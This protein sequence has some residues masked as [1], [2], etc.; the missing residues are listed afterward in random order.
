M[1]LSSTDPLEPLAIVGFSLKFPGTAISPESFWDLILQGRPTAKDVP[2]DRYSVDAW[3]HPDPSHLDTVSQRGGNFLEGDLSQFDAAFFSITASEANAMVPQQRMILE[4]SY[5]ALENAGITM[6]DVSGSKMAVF[7]GVFGTDYQT[8]HSKDPLNLPRFNATG[9]S[10]NMLANR[11]SWFF[12]LDG[13]S[14]NVDTACSSSL[15]AIHLTCQSIWSGESCSGLAIGCNA[16][17]TPDKAIALDNISVLSGD[18]RSYSFDQ[19]ANGYSRGE[20]VG[21]LVIRPLQDAISRGDPIRA[22]IRASALNQ[23]GRTP[24]ITQPSM[25]R[26]AELIRETY[27]RAGLDLSTTRYFETHGTGTSVGDLIESRSIGSVFREYRSAIDP[28]YLG[29]VK[30]NIGHLEGASGVA[31]VIK[32]VLALEKGV[33]PPNSDF[34]TLNPRIDDEFFHLKVPTDA[35]P[36]PSD[37]LRRASISSFG[38]GGSNAHIII[39]DAANTLRNRMKKINSKKI[40][41]TNT[42]LT[43]GS[44]SSMMPNGATKNIDDEAR[45]LVWS[46]ADKDG[47]SRVK[48]AWKTFFASVEVPPGEKCVYLNNLAFTLSIRRSSLPWKSFVVA[49]PDEDWTTMV[50]RLAPASLANSSPNV[51]YIFSGQGAQWHAM[52]RELIHTYPVF[53]HSL[54]EA[55]KYLRGLGCEWDLL[56]TIT[57]LDELCRPEAESNVNRTTYSQTL[58]T[59]L[60]VALVDL[61]NSFGISPK[62]VVGHSSGEIAAAYTA[63]AIS[64]T[65]AWRIAY[66]RGIWGSFLEE[67]SLVRGAMLAVALPVDEISP[68]FDQMEEQHPI[69]RLTVACINSPRS[70]TI[71]GEEEQIDDL[72]DLLDKQ[73]VFNRKLKVKAAY[74]SFQMHEIAKQ[75]RA[76]MG[77]IESGVEQPH[78]NLRPQVVSLLTGTWVE[79]G[80]LQTADYWVENMIS[81]VRF[82]DSLNAIASRVDP[83]TL[84]LDGSHLRS[85]VIHQVIEIGPHSALQGPVK[86]VLNAAASGYVAYASAIVNGVALYPA[87]GML[88]MAIEGAKQLV[89]E[90]REVC[91]FT[92]QDTVF[93]A[94]VQILEQEDIE[95]NFYMH[96]VKNL[97]AKDSDLFEFS[98]YTEALSKVFDPDGQKFVVSK[99]AHTLASTKNTIHPTA[100]DSIL[101][102]GIW[103]SSKGDTKAFPTC[104]PTHLKSIWISAEGLPGSAEVFNVLT[105]VN[106]DSL[107]D[108]S[109]GMSVFDASMNR[110][111]MVI[112]GLEC[113]TVNAPLSEKTN[114]P[115]NGNF[116]T[117]IEFKPDI[118]LLQNDEIDR[119]CRQGV[120]TSPKI[121]DYMTNVHF[122]VLAKV[123]YI[124]RNISQQEFQ[125]K[126]EWYRKYIRWA[127]HQKDLRENGERVFS[128]GPWNARLQDPEFIHQLEDSVSNGGVI[129]KLAVSVSRNLEDMLT[130][131]VDPLEFIF[132]SGLVK[133]YYDARWDYTDISRSFFG[134]AASEFK[135]EG[136]RMD[137]KAL[138]IEQNPEEQG[139]QAGSYDMVLASLVLHATADL[140]QTLKN[141]RRLLKPGGKLVMIEL[142]NPFQSAAT[143]GLLEGWWLSSESYRTL[144]PAV[145]RP[146]WN[147]LLCQSGF[148]GCDL[149]CSDFDEHMLNETAVIVSTAKETSTSPDWNPKIE[150]V[151][152]PADGLQSN[153]ANLLAG[154]CLALR[155]SSH[156]NCVSLG[157]ASSGGDDLFR[158]F[159]LEYGKPALFRMD[160]GLFDGLRSLLTSRATTLWITYSGGT[161]C[162]EPKLHLIDDLFRVLQEE[163]AQ[164]NRFILSLQD[165]KHSQSIMCIIDRIL[166]SPANLDNEYILEHGKLLIPRMVN[167]SR[168]DRVVSLQITESEEALLPFGCGGPLQLDVKASSMLGG[169]KFVQAE[170]PAL[171]DAH[172]V[173]VEV[174]Y[175][176]VNF[177]DVLVALGQ[178]PSDDLGE[179]CMGVVTR[180]G[181]SCKAFQKGDR[182][183]GC[184]TNCYGMRARFHEGGA[185]VRIPP[186]VSSIDAVTI[187]TNFVT[188]YIAIADRAHIQCGESILI[189]S[190]SGGT[191]QA[192]IQIAQHLGA[193][194]FI[195]VG[196]E[197]KTRFMMQ[198]YNIPES[199]IFSSRSMAFAKAI[200]HRTAGRGVDVVLNSLS[201]EG[202]IQSWECIALYGRFVEIGVRDVLANSKLPMGQFL[203]NVTFSALDISAM[204]TER[205]DLCR[206]AL[207]TL[208]T[209]FEEGKL[210]PPEPIQIYGIGQMEKAFRL[211]QSGRNYGKMVIEMR[212]EDPVMTLQKSQP[213]TFL[214][215]GA[216]YVVAGGLGGLGQNLIQWL[217]G[218]GAKHLMILS[219]SGATGQEAKLL[220]GDLR[221]RG[222]T[223]RCPSCD[224]SDKKAVRAVFEEWGPQMPPIKGCIQAAMVLEDT[225]FDNMSYESWNTAVQPKTHGSWNLH[226]VLPEAGNTFQDAL[227]HYRNSIGENAISLDL[228][229]FAFAGR[230]A[231]DPELLARALASNSHE[232]VT[233]S[234]FHA[235]LDCYCN[236]EAWRKMRLPIQPVVGFRTGAGTAASAYWS[237]KPMMRYVTLQGACEGGQDGPGDGLNLADAF[238]S[239]KSAADA[240][241][242]VQTALS[243][244]L[245]G[246]LSLPEADLDVNKPLQ[247]YGVDSLAAV[248]LRGWFCKE[249]Q[250]DIATFDIIGRA[251]IASLAQLATGR[252]KLAKSWSE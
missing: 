199:R 57:L 16:I 40:K 132:S 65:S 130:E 248:E 230:L 117:E 227:A 15:M 93:E 10:M 151:C 42:Q 52:G 98:L 161:A 215:P 138:N 226:Q 162:A 31:G 95:V 14:A 3:H 17:L 141:V 73:S 207:E 203:R 217:L 251:T 2:S 140:L 63:G 66:Y 88:V 6:T 9:T 232:P 76:A 242:S 127:E 156:V 241:T 206:V 86:E 129:G 218:R 108:L 150:I 61:L 169:F 13:P 114:N 168:L 211:M 85:L 58:C 220:V 208:V 158:I 202:L 196:S 1:G 236:P 213:N 209:L 99:V 37:G 154:E 131:V 250:A 11:V 246:T 62:V 26:Q 133:N 200:M 157:D 30:S 12:N 145:D 143:F 71:S 96:P 197:E 231:R 116:S 25:T 177:H 163:D 252:S 244:K 87:A 186:G 64:R 223:I 102:T 106:S 7:S 128:S 47:L 28:L 195:T 137:F 59:A 77:S 159:L 187:P 170:L 153:L 43:N 191:G 50:D 38:F 90:G 216:T 180:V 134:N 247:Q 142:I 84:K 21:V 233:E 5:R 45:L 105:R 78:A 239:A 36:W 198:K 94:T 67:H 122:L 149:F 79:P 112:D 155:P 32:A 51:A 183:A 147:A 107:A 237:E 165:E 100:L 110:P 174:Y 109:Y 39:D 80:A 34:Q 74:H 70:V 184:I 172:K 219:R 18:S 23:D 136:A 89:R 228:G 181:E 182:V 210:H 49:R 54:D 201:G 125:P 97:S 144:G 44:Q 152:D 146:Q 249:V 160:R 192:A 229:T 103:T 139:F 148:S 189:H 225:R 24:G 204:R 245:S 4:A 111:V 118:R 60:Q 222:V 35:V 22:V 113:T 238:Q 123:L 33:I 46:S 91:G 126:K 235:V 69:F 243:Q 175:V 178:V 224:V 68:L 56:G 27:Q 185:V 119:I 104:V 19:R 81:P 72:K 240:S 212:A 193:D 41:F 194:V 92:I 101:Q 205:P 135:S 55:T 164:R 115:V 166:T 173:E 221:A 8:L 120:Q 214:S 75:Y 179:E 82:A 83:P 29:S 176:G 167:S 48:E 124:S 20:G 121:K 234:E 53:R 188:A 171:L 190:G